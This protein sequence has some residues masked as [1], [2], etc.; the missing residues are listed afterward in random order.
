MCRQQ[1]ADKMQV[2]TMA[3]VVGIKPERWYVAGRVSIAGPVKEFTAMDTDPRTPMRC[4]LS[5]KASEKLAMKSSEVWR[6]IGFPLPARFDS[7]PPSSTSGIS[8]VVSFSLHILEG[9]SRTIPDE[10]PRFYGL[11]FSF[12]RSWALFSECKWNQSMEHLIIMM[13]VL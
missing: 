9:R 4:M 5:D 6:F 12:D 8:C 3:A 10:N 1:N 7:P 2:N 11:S 13:I